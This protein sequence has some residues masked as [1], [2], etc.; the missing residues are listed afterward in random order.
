[1][2]K[3]IKRTRAVQEAQTLGK[4]LLGT[5]ALKRKRRLK[6]VEQDMPDDPEFY[7]NER[8]ERMI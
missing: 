3:R 1:M 2:P 4:K 7:F 8:A 6:Q 5:Y